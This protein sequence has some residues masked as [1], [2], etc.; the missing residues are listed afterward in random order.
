MAKDRFGHGMEVSDK[1]FKEIKSLLDGSDLDIGKY[2]GSTAFE[3]WTSSPWKPEDT[4]FLKI[5]ISKT[6]ESYKNNKPSYVPESSWNEEYM[7]QYSKILRLA[8]QK[9]GAPPPEELHQTLREM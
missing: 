5:L 7:E 6:A 2:F 8:S 1:A 9:K 3:E 4:D